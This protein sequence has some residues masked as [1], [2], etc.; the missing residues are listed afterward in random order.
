V[1]P[2]TGEKYVYG[3]VPAS[4]KT[5]SGTGIARRRLHT[6][7]TD[8]A[9][10]IVSDVPDG[11][12]EVGREDLMVHARVLERALQGGVVLPMRFGVVM[13]DERAVRE[14]LLEGF[15]HDLVS[16]LEELEGKVELHLRAVYNEEALMREIVE[17]NPE[18]ARRSAALQGQSADATYFERIELGQ[19][20]AEAVE[21]ARDIDTAAILDELEPL[22]IAVDVGSPDHER[23]VASISFLIE[24]DRLVSFDQAVDDLGRRSEGRLQFTYT[25]PL[26]AYSFVD[27]PGQGE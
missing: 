25:G 2:T 27:L 22:S 26:P 9:A 18:I 21:R 13:S 10:A 8:D 19:L 7:R 5:P 17:A 15:H 12:V 23:V 6:V 11:E 1:R 4:A 14:Q 20:V 24:Q 3:I 16:Q